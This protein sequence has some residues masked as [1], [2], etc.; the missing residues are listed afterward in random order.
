MLA[1]PGASIFLK[2]WL[3]FLLSW[4]WPFQKEKIQNFAWDGEQIWHFFS[5][6]LEMFLC[7]FFRTF[8]CFEME[9]FLPEMEEKSNSLGFFLEIFWTVLFL[10]SSSFCTWL[11]HPLFIIQVSK[12]AGMESCLVKMTWGLT[13]MCSIKVPNKMSH[14]QTKCLALCFI[15]DKLLKLAAD[16]LAIPR[17]LFL[18]LSEGLHVLAYTHTPCAI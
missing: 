7:C 14:G 8:S 2:Q 18:W 10:L 3:Q 15:Q 13:C 1:T 4:F 9:S 5:S 12:N 6:F 16:M 17:E 11:W